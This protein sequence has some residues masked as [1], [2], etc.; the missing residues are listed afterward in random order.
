MFTHHGCLTNRWFPEKSHGPL[1]ADDYAGTT[2]EVLAPHADKLLMPR[3]IRAMNEWTV[4]MSLGQ[5]NDYHTQVVGTY[6]TC[7]PITPH[8]DDPFSFEAETKFEA[9]PT[10]PSLDHVCARQLH[11]DGT[12]L[13]MRVS[14]RSEYTQGAISYSDN[15]TPFDGIG[16][17]SEVFSAITG[18]FADD[19]VMS[20]D[21]YRLARG[22]SVID[23]VAADLQTLEGFGMSSSDRRKLEAWKDLL[24]ETGQVVGS[25]QCGEESALALSL[26]EANLSASAGLGGDALSG[27][28]TDDLDGAD[29]FSNLAV[30]SALCDQ[31]RVT[32]LK[33]PADYIYSGLG[34]TVS[35]DGMAHRTGASGLGGSCAADVNKMILAVDHFYAAKF[36]HLV[37]Q[38]DRFEEGDGTLLDNCAAVWF[39]ATSDGCAMNLN[40]MPI[41]Q[42]GGCGGYLKTGQAVNV[43]DG[44]SDLD[45]GNSE[46]MCAEEGATFTAADFKLFGTPPEIANAPINKYYCNLM[47]AIGV[48]AGDDGFPAIGGAEEVTHYGMYDRTE[49]FASG[50]ALPP[51]ISDPGGFEELEASA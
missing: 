21:E 46:A 22:Q 49:D 8:A 7:V 9:M 11:A 25:V 4:D 33:Y 50:G 15:Q 48:K 20:P 18:L 30:L 51:T 32:F 5:G 43:D 26:T 35:T 14:G 29:I 1:T 39:Q 37:A 10:A 42:A 28:V 17:A 27:M 16:S 41:L 40:N 12:P 13:F 31:S 3:G 38:L 6:F 44:T 2:L 36:A 45:R 47:N 34:L 23:L 19:S 24:H